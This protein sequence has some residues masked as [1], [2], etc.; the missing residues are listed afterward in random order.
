MW[1]FDARPLRVKAHPRSSNASA[2]EHTVFGVRTDDSST[3]TAHTPLLFSF[4]FLH[5][6]NCTGEVLLAA[7]KPPQPSLCSSH[8]PDRTFVSV[9]RTRSGAFIGEILRRFTSSCKKIKFVMW[10]RA[11]LAA[12]EAYSCKYRSLLAGALIGY[13]LWSCC[14]IKSNLLTSIIAGG[15]SLHNEMIWKQKM[16]HQS[17]GNCLESE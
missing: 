1:S 16:D 4:Y 2:W 9:Y 7:T 13:L 14:R 6:C 12:A 10:W 8:H 17:L 5:S 3:L 11:D 15:D